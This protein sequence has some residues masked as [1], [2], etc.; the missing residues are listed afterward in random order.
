MSSAVPLIRVRDIKFSVLPTRT[1]FPFRYGIAAMTEA[2]HLFVRSELE[3]EGITAA[4][5]ASEGLP[6]KWFTKNVETTF[7][8]DDLPGMKR[9]IL[10]AAGFATEIT[11]SLSFFEFWK[12]L[13]QRQESWAKTESIPPLLAQLGTALMERTVLDGLCRYLEKPLHHVVSENH[14]GLDW[15]EIHPELSDVNPSSVFKNPPLD[16]VRA[17]HTV[18]LADPLTDSEIPDSDRIDDGLP[19]SLVAN[20]RTYGL[21]HFKLKLCGNLETDRDRL[22]ELT[23]LF[24][25]EAPEN[26]EITIDGNEQYADI[27]AFR[28]HF[29][30]HR[31]DPEIFPIFDHLLFV[32]QPIHRDFALTDPVKSGFENW[33]D[34]P[35][36]IIDESDGEAGSLPRALELGYVGTSH[37]NC[38]GVVK[39]LANR[40]LLNR[41]GGV[42]SGE[43]LANLGPIAL[44]QDLAVAALL[45]IDHVER[46]GHH[47]FAGL[48]MFPES[49]QQAV[50]KCHP[51][52]YA[53]TETGF[54]ALRIEQGRISTGSINAA[55]FGVGL[56]VDA[57]DGFDSWT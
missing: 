45:G 54:P 8:E 37:K 21:T 44:S 6:P 39:S 31:A 27:D 25:A 5:I 15:G 52:L 47:Y 19:H 23:A 24:S 46:N 41:K 13:K 22:R 42:M 57:F 38:K 28:D 3:I 10:Q 1:R 9:V 14:I 55:P 29:L 17:R 51:D 11:E 4:G 32:E 33:P 53:K 49:I 16:S 43:D 40:A 50:L 18:G 26:Y 2:P 7:E 48:S 56:P 35:P 34:A 20:I 12:A 30:E 36:V